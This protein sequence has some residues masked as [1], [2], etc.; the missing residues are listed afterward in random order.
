MSNIVIL[1]N[2]DY[3]KFELNHYKIFEFKKK[4]F[5][6]AMCKIFYFLNT[7]LFYFRNYNESKITSIIII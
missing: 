3:D 1:Y 7:K 5:I 2:Y 4:D 6:F